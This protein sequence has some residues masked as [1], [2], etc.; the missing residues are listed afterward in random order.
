MNVQSAS[1]A[2]VP[3]A[4]YRQIWPWLLISLP[5]SAVIAGFLTLYLAWKS[6][7]G[8][9]ANDYYKEGLEINHALES[10]KIAQQLGMNG[11]L[12]LNGE[13][14]EVRLSAARE[15]SFPPAI[16]LK[17]I[18]PVRAGEDQEVLLTGVGGVYTGALRPIAAG[19][20]TLAVEDEA[21][22]W[23]LELPAVLPLAGA[24]ELKP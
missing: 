21:K 2:V 14:A 20:W 19:H 12:K 10:R 15:I 7:D 13:Q 1:M 17:V 16:R 22:T 11:E 23:R 18:N 9:V 8:L 6:N 3:R 24:I 4:W 5:L